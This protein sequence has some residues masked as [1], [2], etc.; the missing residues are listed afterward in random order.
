M[1]RNLIIS[2]DIDSFNLDTRISALTDI[3]RKLALETKAYGVIN[4]ACSLVNMHIHSFYSFNSQGYSPAHIALV[5]RQKGL[6]AAALCDFDV[7]DGL[8]EFIAA[9][10]M[11]G[12]RT[13]VHLETR[14][15]LKEYALVDINSPGEPGVTYILGAGFGCLPAPGSTA[16]KTLS[17]FRQQANLRNRALVGR[18]NAC[19]PEISIDYNADV[20][21]L[22][23]GG[24][25][26]ERHIV[27]AYRLKAQ[28]VFQ[29][30]EQLTSFW[31]K[32]LR[33]TDQEVGKL[34][35]DLPIMDEKVRALLAKSGG[36]GYVRPDEKTFPPVDDFIACVLQ[37]E[38]IPMA[39]WL[40]GTSK[41]EEDMTGMLECLKAKGAA[42][43][44]II[45]D[46]V[47]NLAN[48]DERRIKTRNLNKVILAARKLA[49]PI[50]IGTEMNKSGQPFVDNLECD[51][52]APYRQ[53]FLRGAN[54]MIGQTILARY[55]D[56]SY[57]GKSALSEY[58][59][60]TVRKNDF[61]EAVGKLPPLSVNEAARLSEMGK[62][63]AFQ[64]I[65]DSVPNRQWK[66]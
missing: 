2:Q 46:R 49:F 47:H 31:S 27:Q 6:Y 36:I 55:A 61:F 22:S 50:N 41:G 42:A 63:K 37:C 9:G 26:T 48:A 45:L 66:F 34:L 52:L 38:A 24:C 5:C 11:L 10:Q 64:F 21:P 18:I 51:A 30:R 12:L 29:I 19:L 23:P 13:A 54:I 25:P 43:L 7:L 65:C 62:E 4:R 1:S 59:A 56:F 57:C 44:N 3:A 58:G 39:S 60:D 16:M 35:N 32:L 17:A 20:I 28:A 15:Y 14:A 33:K 40:D 8:E 53:D